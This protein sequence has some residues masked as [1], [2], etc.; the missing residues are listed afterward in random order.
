MTGY[1]IGHGYDAHRFAEGRPLILGGVNVPYDRGL[2]GHS[3]ADA[4]I[5]AVIDALLGA[6][7]LGNIGTEFPDSD[8]AYKDADSMELLVKLANKLRDKRY[9]VV[10]VD[11]TIVAQEPRLSAYLPG[12]AGN[13]ASA[14]GID[15]GCVS[16]KAKTEEGMGFTGSGQGIS[17]HAVCLLAAGRADPGAPE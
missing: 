9:G 12:M 7:A 6:A 5:H 3:D 11:S 4:L 10:N 8:P 2:L 16:V 13:I 15:T 14:L 17:C 1:R